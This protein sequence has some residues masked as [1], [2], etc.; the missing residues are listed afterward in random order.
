MEQSQ[1]R[2]NS[3]RAT[4]DFVQITS[5]FIASLIN[6]FIQHFKNINNKQPHIST[7]RQAALKYLLNFAS[8]T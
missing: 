3:S 5:E 2:Q 6:I 7:S 1:F 4:T 8:V